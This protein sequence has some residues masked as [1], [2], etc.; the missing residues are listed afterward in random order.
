MVPEPMEMFV[1]NGER[2]R[3]FHLY[4]P[5][6]LVCDAPER[7]CQNSSDLI[8]DCHGVFCHSFWDGDKHIVTL[9]A[10]SERRRLD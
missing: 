4:L 3:G 9:G 6:A 8:Q 10:W 5:D 1:E 2:L 7:P